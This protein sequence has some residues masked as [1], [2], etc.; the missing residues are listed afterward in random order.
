MLSYQYVSE[1]SDEVISSKDSSKWIEDMKEE[2]TSLEKN[3]T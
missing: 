2:M 3:Q 1:S